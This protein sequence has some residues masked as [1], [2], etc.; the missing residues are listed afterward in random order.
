M[1][2]VNYYQHNLTYL[3]ERLLAAP[4]QP[5]GSHPLLLTAAGVVWGHT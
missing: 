1:I 5:R 3:L 4:T 2:H